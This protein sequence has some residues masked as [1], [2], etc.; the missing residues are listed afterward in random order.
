[1][2]VPEEIHLTEGILHTQNTPPHY[3]A[4]ELITNILPKRTIRDSEHCPL[5]RCA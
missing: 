1:M 3:G 5:C 4:N 2:E